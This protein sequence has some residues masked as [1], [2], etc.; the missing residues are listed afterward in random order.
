MSDDAELRALERLYR[1]GNTAALNAMYSLLCTVA[2][3]QI[4]AIS[5]G[6]AH[7]KQLAAEDRQAKAHDAATYIIE[8][9][10]KR[11]DFA[12]RTSATGYLYKRV[13]WELF[14]VRKCDKI[15]TYC[16]PPKTAAAN[17]QQRRYVVTDNN[18]GDSVTYTTLDELRDRFPKLRVDKLRQCI[19]A[20]EAYK[21]YQITFI[22]IEG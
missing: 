2:Y 12:I 14:H 17:N 19:T 9:Y 22:E 3:K 16:D 20:G 21:H 7:I 6:N 10:I 1:S 4:N 18:T 13:Q 15:V 5:N 11:P 8:Q